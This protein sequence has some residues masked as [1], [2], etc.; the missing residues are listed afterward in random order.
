MSATNKDIPAV[1][2]KMLT[3]HLLGDGVS[4]SHN[5][6]HNS[7]S[8]TA[9]DGPIKEAEAE[10]EAEPARSQS[11]PTKSQ[12]QSKCVV[13]YDLDAVEAS[14]STCH[15]AFPSHFSPHFAM[16]S[17]PLR[18]YITR[19]LE[20]G[21]GLECASIVE[22]HHALACGC[23]ASRIVFDSPC[24]TREELAFCLQ[25]GVSINADNF[26]E[27]ELI[28]SWIKCHAMTRNASDD[29]ASRSIVGLRI[30]PLVG[31]GDNAFL[32]VSTTTSKFGIPL[33]RANKAIILSLF[34]SYP[35]LVALHSHVGSQ[36]MSLD[37][38]AT[39]AAILEQ[40]ANDIDAHVG[41]SRVK[42]LNIGGGLS[43]NYHGE[44]VTPSFVSYVAALERHAPKLMTPGY[45]RT[46]ITEFGRA[47]VAKT[48]WVVALVEYVKRSAD[49]PEAHQTA[50]IH[51]GSELFL[52]ACYVPTLFPHR[53]ELYDSTGAAVVTTK[54][55][56][57]TSCCQTIAGP[58]CFG[59][60]MIGRNITYL[61]PMRRGDYCVIRDTGSNTYSLFS[62]HCSRP[63]PA[64]MGYRKTKTVVART[65]HSPPPHDPLTSSPEEHCSG[66]T[67]PQDMSKTFHTTIP[68]VS[69]EVSVLKRQE[70]VAQVL[71]FWE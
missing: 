2:H 41:I 42:V 22:V 49:N 28:V 46:V 44:E 25:A 59:G 23:P 43:V 30:N 56:S 29:Y 38:L 65:Q 21:L 57:T 37:A 60:D 6:D 32:S 11:S 24:K 50:I 14:F 51:A 64:V 53:L 9:I 48:A 61:P 35:W 5:N 34:S 15:A 58:L 27:L 52:R 16:K 20:A 62:R 8:P 10:A 33:T 63:A 12:S 68:S 13:V 45:P 26:V 71:S 55:D 66:H 54:E 40:L 67:H 36:G 69:F 3:T 47:L 7:F 4:T 39:G 70:T 19:V 17:C 1:L 31:A 18:F